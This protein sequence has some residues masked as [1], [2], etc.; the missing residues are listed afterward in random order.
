MSG[1]HLDAPNSDVVQ[2]IAQGDYRPIGLVDGDGNCH[3]VSKD[4]KTSRELQV[5]AN[6]FEIRC[7]HGATN[8]PEN[9]KHQALLDTAINYADTYNEDLIK[10]T[11]GHYFVSFR[12]DG[13]RWTVPDYFEVRTRDDKD[14]RYEF[15]AF[16]HDGQFGPCQTNTRCGAFVRVLSQAINAHNADSLDKRFGHPRDGSDMPEKLVRTTLDS[17]EFPNLRYV[18]SASNMHY[19]S[20]QPTDISYVSCWSTGDNHIA[21]QIDPS[22]GSREDLMCWTYLRISDHVEVLVQIERVDLS[23]VGALILDLHEKM[24]SFAK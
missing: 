12:A 22:M 24:A 9:P 20:M 3:A 17:M 4:S 19:F 13:I 15:D 18:G 11:G 1:F 5:F 21:P 14:R 2:H 23:H 8:H 16:W 7:L 10:D 6:N